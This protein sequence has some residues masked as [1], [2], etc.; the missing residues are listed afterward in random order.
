MQVVWFAVERHAALVPALVAVI[1]VVQRL[2]QIAHEV[3]DEPQS[4]RLRLPV[5]SRVL[6]NC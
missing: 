4:F 5:R 1:F 6:Q 2:V 3:N